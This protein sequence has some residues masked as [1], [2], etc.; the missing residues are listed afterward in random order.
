ASAGVAH[1]GSFPASA[2]WLDY[3]RDGDLDL[4]VCNYV[5]YRS[6]KDD[7]PCTFKDGVRSYCIPFAYPAETDCLYENLG[8]GKFRDVAARAGVQGKDGK[9]LGVAVWDL[10]NDGWPDLIIANDTTPTYA[11]INQKDGTFKEEA[12]VK[13][14]AYGITG[15]AKAGMGV[16]I[17][18]DRNTGL[19]TV[20]MSNF[21]GELVG[22]Y[23]DTGDGFFHEQSTECGIGRPSEPYLGFGIF[24]FDYNNDG[25]QDLYVANGH[26]QDKIALFSEGVT[27]EEPPLLYRNQGGGRYEEVGRQA[28]PGFQKKMVA[29]GAAWGDIDDDGRL[30]IV[31]NANQGPATLWANDSAGAGHWLKVK[32]VGAR[33]NRNGYGA[34]LVLESSAGRQTREARAGSSYCSQSD[35]RLQFGLGADTSA[36]S[37]QI[38][39]PSGTVDTLRDI[40]ADQLLTVREG[41]HPEK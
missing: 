14:I 30:D 11:Y 20:V 41:T 22:V 10:N 27:Y 40:P 25:W 5:R 4:Y 18:D 19:P 26:V 31:V 29:R 9:S 7:L 21:S 35:Q 17:A 37:L 28:G 36:R 38:R 12:A 32:L 1:P 39:W 16:D 34:R 3:D 24:F 8:N 33:S 15:A 2:A 6:V 23:R 13:G